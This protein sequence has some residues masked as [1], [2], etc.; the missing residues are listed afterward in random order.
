MW[1]LTSLIFAISLIDEQLIL[2]EWSNKIEEINVNKLT[3]ELSAAAS[4]A[5]MIVANLLTWKKYT[6]IF[7]LRQ[8][9]SLKKLQ[10]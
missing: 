6:N 9:K 1:P 7:I 8:R 5:G 4:E 10:F 3:N 2:Y